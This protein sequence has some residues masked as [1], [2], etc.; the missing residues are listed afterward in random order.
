M[1][2]VAAAARRFALRLA[3]GP[4][5]IPCTHMS[6]ARACLSV[7]LSALL[8]VCLTH[9]RGLTKPNTGLPLP[10]RQAFRLAIMPAMTGVAAEVPSTALQRGREEGSNGAEEV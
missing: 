7:C 3:R 6:L 9:M 2:A 1:D 5:A 4:S 10:R 8:T